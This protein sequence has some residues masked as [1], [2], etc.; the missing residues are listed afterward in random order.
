MKKNFDT[1][2]FSCIIMFLIGFSI[3]SH[4]DFS[5]EIKDECGIPNCIDFRIE[6]NGMIKKSDF[7][8]F[9]RALK[10][11]EGK[12]HALNVRLNSP[13]GDLESAIAIGR[14]VRKFTGL[15][16]TF[17]D[18][19]CY[20]SCV[21]ILAGGTSRI[22]SSTIGIHRPYS[23][24]TENRKY[25]DIQN[26]QRHL[27]K[28][29]KEYLEEMNVLPSLYDAMVVI[30]PERIKLL[31]PLDLQSYGILK[32]DPVMQE[33]ND[34]IEAREYGLSKIEFMKRKS[35]VGVIC[36]NEH[37]YGRAIGNFKAYYACEER[38]FRSQ[39]TR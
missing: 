32:I 5:V 18:G 24:S 33:I 3:N 19:V 17:D 16:I 37:N 2:L 21:F 15:V 22:L 31:S 14:L 6:I 11:S 38:V 8:D 12:A 25:Q 7:V 13:G 28:I 1:L 35:Q 4:A 30:P 36:A 39:S 27:A 26:E 23:I 10:I 29:A 34:S 9:S 20:S